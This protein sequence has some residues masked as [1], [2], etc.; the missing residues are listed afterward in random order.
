MQQYLHG[1]HQSSGH[2]LVNP[3]T[4]GTTKYTDGASCLGVEVSGYH[5]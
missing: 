5:I 2:I 4:L 1:N 3:G